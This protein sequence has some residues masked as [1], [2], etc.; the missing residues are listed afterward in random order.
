M[1]RMAK[2]LLFLFF[3]FFTIM[4]Q[5][6]VSKSLSITVYNANLGVV[7]DVR[8]VNIPSGNSE[9]K[10]RNVAQLIDPTSVHIKLD[11]EV[12][13]QNYQY[14]LVSLDKILQKYIDK[15]IQLVSENNEVITGRLLSNYG[16]QIVIEK[17]EGGL[18]M[19]PSTE[20]YRFS[21]GSLP[22]GLITVPTLVWL[23]NSNGAKDQE[24][25]LSYQTAGMNWHAEYVAVLNENDT[26]LDLNSWVSIENNSGAAYKNATLKLVAGDVNIIQSQPQYDLMEERKE[27]MAAAPSQF[28]EREFF[29][30]HIYDLNRP[31]TLAN[32]ETKQ[33]S[34]FTASNINITKKYLYRNDFHWYSRPAEQN[35]KV[36]VAVEFVNSEGNNLGM[37]FPK[38]K[39]RVYKTD[40]SS[41][42]FIGED[43][44]DHTPKDEKVKLKIGEAFD[45]RVE[46]KMTENRRIT[47]K[48]YEQDYEITFRNRK[49]EDIVID[50]ERI[51][52]NN[53]EILSSSIKFEKQDASTI[54]FKVPVAKNSETTL[55]YKVRYTY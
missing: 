12:I 9:L 37:P 19:L 44:V 54:L 52:G 3:P 17:K 22:E 26:K 6:G 30:Y 13:E 53:W 24:I 15:E 47:D 42:E 10:I 55:K 48:V 16:G 27:M 18:V 35:N 36:S 20:K 51:L 43:L 23:I 41:A 50:V 29:E 8:N 1:I 4:A 33:I 2:G 21:V 28:G 39:V 46:D 32:N 34:L 31:T 49:N 38:G 7:K 25:E 5:E 11:G 14:D 40:G 45:I